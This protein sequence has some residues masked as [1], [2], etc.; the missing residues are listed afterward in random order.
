MDVPLL[1]KYWWEVLTP[2]TPAALTPISLTY[3]GPILGSRVLLG[4]LATSGV[5]SDI[6]FLLSDPDFL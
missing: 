5:K 2:V 3:Q 1:V 4:Y 6:I